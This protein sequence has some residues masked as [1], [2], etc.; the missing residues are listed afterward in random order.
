MDDYKLLKGY[1]L[2]SAFNEKAMQAD[3]GHEYLLK[4]FFN[5][6]KTG[7]RS[8]PITLER[9]DAVAELT[10]VVDQLACNGG[11]IGDISL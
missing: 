6:I 7:S 5:T 9:L 4:D 1:G 2:P 11:G 3:K 10:L 8:L